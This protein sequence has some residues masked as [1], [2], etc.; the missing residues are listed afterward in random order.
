MA[1]EAI[2]VAYSAEEAHALEV[3]RAAWDD[4]ERLLFKI[5]DAETPAESRGGLRVD[6]DAAI[7]CLTTAEANAILTRLVRLR[8]DLAD[9]FA[10]AVFPDNMP[11]P[12]WLGA[13]GRP[14]PVTSP[15]AALQWR[16][17]EGVPQSP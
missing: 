12:D 10:L 6:L 13:D 16:A 14:L 11:T 2:I 9:L 7:G 1:H 17:F 15:P 8:P 3:R 4:V 5:D